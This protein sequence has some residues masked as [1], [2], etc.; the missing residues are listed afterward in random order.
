LREIANGSCHAIAIK[1][2][3]CHLPHSACHCI[4]IYSCSSC[5][6]RDV[7]TNTTVI[8]CTIGVHD[9]RL[10]W[11]SFIRSFKLTK[12]KL[13]GEVVRKFYLRLYAACGYCSVNDIL[14][15]IQQIIIIEKIVI[16]Q[17][18]VGLAHTRPMQL[19]CCSGLCYEYT[20][21]T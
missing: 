4:G 16:K 17:T 6:F 11:L 10:S 20:I 14:N 1:Q 9:P 19:C 18:T 12:A 21:G 15:D 13:A 7:T 2:N 3:L 5:L 8:P